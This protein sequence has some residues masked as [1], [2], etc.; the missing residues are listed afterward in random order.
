MSKH[1]TQPPRRGPIDFY[2]WLVIQSATWGSIAFIGFSF[3]A[4]WLR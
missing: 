4:G 2:G 3:F 1:A